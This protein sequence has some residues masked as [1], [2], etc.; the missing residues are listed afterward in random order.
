MIIRRT[1]ARAWGAPPARRQRLFFAGERALLDRPAVAVLLGVSGRQDHAGDATEHRGHRVRGARATLGTASSPAANWAFS[2]RGGYAGGRKW[3]A[4]SST[5]PPAACSGTSGKNPCARCLADGRAWRRCRV[6]ASRG[7]VHG[8]AR[9]RP[10]TS[11]CSPLRARAF[12]FNNDGEARRERD[13]LKRGLCDWLYAFTGFPGNHAL[14]AR[15]AQL[16]PRHRRRGVPPPCLALEDVLHATVEHVRQ[17]V[18]FRA[19]R[20]PPAAFSRLCPKT[21]ARRDGPFHR[22]AGLKGGGYPLLR[23]ERSRVRA[24]ERGKRILLSCRARR[25]PRAPVQ[26]APGRAR[27]CTR[28]AEVLPDAWPYRVVFLRAWLVST[29]HQENTI[30]GTGA[31]CQA[32]RRSLTKCFQNA[33]FAMNAH[34]LYRHPCA[35]A[36]GAVVPAAA[37]T[38]R[39]SA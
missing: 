26:S 32:F 16:L 12:V 33:R 15:G 37:A 3:A 2:P 31:S 7:A 20:L 8:I 6:G 25:V 39:D 29:N 18:I 17:A 5:C 19:A 10:A 14:V 28:G 9:H 27:N 22:R 23:R 34:R 21:S 4:R 35:A 13:M 36:C 30:T 38:P 1:S 24:L 11:W